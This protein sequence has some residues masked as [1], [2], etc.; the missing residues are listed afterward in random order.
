MLHANY[1][2]AI[3]LGARRQVWWL[4]AKKV[5]ARLGMSAASATSHLRL[6]RIIS[7]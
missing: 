7:S 3:P 2:D 5:M 6:A 4:S 1:H